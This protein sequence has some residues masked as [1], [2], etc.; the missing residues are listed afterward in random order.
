MPP[1]PPPPPGSAPASALVA[2][3]TRGYRTSPFEDAASATADGR[4][5]Q[6]D[7]EAIREQ[8]PQV[9]RARALAVTKTKSTRRL[10]PGDAI[11][12]NC[13]E[14]NIPTRKFCSRCGESLVEAERV[15]LSWWRRLLRRILPRRGPKVVKLKPGE[16]GKPGT[17]SVPKDRDFNLKHTLGQIYRKGR[18]VVA[19]AAIFGGILYGAYPPFRNAI[20]GAVTSTKTRI[21][22]DIGDDLS[23]IHPD[24]VT[25]NA[26]EAGHPANL[27]SD[28]FTNTYWSA[29][30]T[31]SPEPTL[32]VTFAHPVTL[33]KLIL[34]NG[35][36]GNY[37]ADGRP[38]SLHLIFSNQES[39]TVTPQDT[40]TQQTFSLS[41][42]DLI[43]SIQIQVTAVY[44]GSTNDDVAI[45]EIELF[46]LP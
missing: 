1:P 23:P 2:P 11:C 37:I 46:G 22:N 5:N 30:W 7:D 17:V 8:A 19:I 45:T 24:A 16:A 38:S 12:G 10:Q 34:F 36:A 44:Q 29:P 26:S 6:G 40:T 39:D 25:A 13:G 33:R 21:S 43:K 20:N 14:G 28:E 41:H 35:A 9:A 42:A 31:T 27:A 32:T 15:K 4:A 3:V 18:L